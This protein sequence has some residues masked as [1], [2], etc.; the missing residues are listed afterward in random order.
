MPRGISTP[1]SR[2]HY[3]CVLLLLCLF[4]SATSALAQ[5]LSSRYYDENPQGLFDDIFTLADTTLHYRTIGRQPIFDKLVRYGV[6]HVDYS[7]RGEF[8]ESEVVRL[9]AHNI[10]SPLEAWNDY[11]L[12]S[13]LR[14]VPMSGGYDHYHKEALHGADLRSEWFNP[15]PSLLPDSRTIKMNYAERSYR[16]GVNYSAVGSLGERWRYSLAV[17]AKGGRDAHVEGVF[18]RQAYLWVA[19]ERGTGEWESVYGNVRS[20]LLVAFALSPVE[21]SGRSWNTEEVF[22][23]ASNP[24][25]NSSWGYQQGEVRSANVRRELVPVL[26]G[27]WSVEDEFGIAGA[28]LSAMIRGGRKARTALDWNEA[29]SPQPDWYGYLPSGYDDPTLAIEAEGVWRRDDS[30]YTQIDWDKLYSINRRSPRGAVYALSEDRSDLFSAEVSLS[31]GEGGRRVENGRNIL[32]D[33]LFGGLT[34]GYHTQHN[35][36]ALVDLLGGAYAS[37]GFDE[38]DY[39]VE[40]L[41]AEL[42]ES[43]TTSNDWGVFGVSGSLGGHSLRYHSPL[44]GI[45][46]ALRNQT[47]AALKTTWNYRLDPMG[48]LSAVVHASLRSPHH[49]NI[50]AAPE[51]RATLNPHARV[52]EHY[53]L[54]L[55]GEW[56]KWHTMFSA[57]LWA[58]YTQHASANSLFWNDIDN[59]Y[60]ALV[61]G[62]MEH[63][64]V[65][66]E[67]DAGWY[68][69][70]K[71][72]VEGA[73]SVGTW[74]YAGDA[75]ADLI[76]SA[77]GEVQVPNVA[78][79]LKGLHSNS[80]PSVVAVVKTTYRPV[81][82]WIFTLEG[83]LAAGR[84]VEPSLFLHSDYLLGRNLSPEERTQLTTQASL[85]TAPNLSVVVCRRVGRALVSLSVRNLLGWGGR[86]GGYQPSRLHVVE[87][88]Y[89][90][91]YTPH[92]NRY[93]N[94]YPR[95]FNL[96]FGYD[97]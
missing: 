6:L 35:H 9:G 39:T 72:S 86:Y 26:Y 40:H 14:R 36:S 11:N 77:T 23:L 64:S 51:E 75:V 85:G 2:A 52:E 33:G 27:A 28:T 29:M 71:W 95:T 45:K 97:F 60:S 1:I 90:I 25:Y 61:A 53:G 56:R 38:Y 66:V 49:R 55:R 91:G 41:G 43:W 46:F 15:A 54:N 84:W 81:R 30:N 34:L 31:G 76:D 96:T 48:N 44:T 80:S 47:S 32:V 5:A 19:A 70:S 50:F 74:R 88:E 65:G 89:A 22:D 13:L 68:P 8:S 79:R 69:S 20:R 94:I 57:T 17:G 24:L 73:F 7:R 16:L 62:E 83:A 42:Y 93:Q 12:L 10:L 4:F 92:T 59:S 63:Y 21:R 3:K 87:K 82:G 37:A 78:L 67:V 18:S 58:N